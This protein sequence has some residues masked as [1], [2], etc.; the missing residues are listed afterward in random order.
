MHFAN[1]LTLSLA[2]TALA[3]PITK[4][5]RALADYEAVF[6]NISSQVAVVSDTVASYVSGSTTGDAVQ[7][8]SN[9]LVTVINDG[10]TSV[11]TFDALS[12]LD[13]LALV[14]PIQ[15][16][17]ADV[18]DLVDAVIAAEPNFETDGLSGNVLASLQAQKGAAE[19]LRDAVT[20]KVPSALQEIAA[21][22]AEGI[23]AEIERGIVAYS[24]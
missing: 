15:D 3:A 12:S 21:E 1:I 14:R 9:D 16:L 23:V 17:T 6:D 4:T 19:A 5:K 18:G 7:S 24:D 13:A 20:P 2:T 11:A 10:A 8:A 22:L